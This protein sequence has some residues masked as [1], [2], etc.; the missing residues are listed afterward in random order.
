MTDM[1]TIARIYKGLGF[2][3]CNGCQTSSSPIPRDLK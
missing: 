1:W 3:V 2:E